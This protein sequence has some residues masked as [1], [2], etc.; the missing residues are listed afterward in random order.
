MKKKSDAM[1]LEERKRKLV[2]PGDTTH[3]HALLRWILDGKAP[4]I[5]LLEIFSP[6]ENMTNEEKE[7]YAEKALS[8]LKGKPDSGSGDSTTMKATGSGR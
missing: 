4:N 2:D 6:M 3:R 5:T 8:R 1:I 7:A